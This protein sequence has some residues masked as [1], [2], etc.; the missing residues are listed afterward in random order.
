MI[1]CKET[2]DSGDKPRRMDK[3]SAI[4]RNITSVETRKCKESFMLLNTKTAVLRPE[5]IHFTQK[6][7]SYCLNISTLHKMNITHLMKGVKNQKL[8][9]PSTVETSF[10]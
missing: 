9:I 5:Y 7:Q 6:Q 2:I 3:D 10:L 4:Y 8:S 1:T